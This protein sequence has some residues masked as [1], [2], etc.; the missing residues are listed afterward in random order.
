MQRHA[1]ILQRIATVGLQIALPLI[2]LLSPLYLLVSP[3]FVR[4]EYRLSHIPASTRLASAER[5]AISDVLIGYL[6]GW[7]TLEDMTSLTTSAGEPA[8]TEREISHMVDVKR[9]LG[10]FLAA[11]RLAM[12]LAVLAGVWLLYDVGVVQLGRQLRLAAVT[13][14]AI[15][16]ALVAAS[17]VDFD[18]FFTAF[19]QLLFE[20]GTWT[21]WE[22]DTL[23]QLYPLPFWA[24]AVWKLGGLI[25][26]GLGLTYAV[27]TILSKP[28]RSSSKG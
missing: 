12:G 21:F 1:G 25:L 6:R 17:L 26:V 22:T 7:N 5:L 15:I 4:H 11:Q 3:A 8:L 9:V 13:A 18:L 16:G 24:D 28:R 27:G 2:L 19:H 20:E 10:W 14:A 23:I